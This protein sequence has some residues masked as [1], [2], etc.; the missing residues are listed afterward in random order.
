[1]KPRN[2]N[3]QRPCYHCHKQEAAPLSN[4]CPECRAANKLIFVPERQQASPLTR[5]LYLG[6]VATTVWLIFKAAEAIGTP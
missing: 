2:P 1:M 5:L 4:F 6:A 3:Y